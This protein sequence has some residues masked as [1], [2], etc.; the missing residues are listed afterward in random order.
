M[1]ECSLSHQKGLGSSVDERHRADGGKHVLR[2]DQALS[3]APSRR[4]RVTRH[5]TFDSG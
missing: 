2:L 5:Y 1:G 3:D 4:A